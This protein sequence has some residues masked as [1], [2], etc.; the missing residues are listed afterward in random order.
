M[1]WLSCI[2]KGGNM[3]LEELKKD[4]EILPKTLINEIKIFLNKYPKIIKDMSI[5]YET[6]VR[7]FPDGNIVDLDIKV[8][9]KI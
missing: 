7:S 3:S 4:K 2:H 5:D 9:I 8:D 1:L 6:I